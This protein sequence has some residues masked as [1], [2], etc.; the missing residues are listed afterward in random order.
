MWGNRAD[1]FPP[2]HA[3]VRQAV[4]GHFGGHPIHK[5]FIKRREEDAN[6]SERGRWLKIV[7]GRR[8][9]G[10]TFAPTREGANFDHGFGIHG[11]A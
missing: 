6:G 9:Q 8:D 5:Q 3:S 11:D 2:L 4:T 1:G 7:I 10:A